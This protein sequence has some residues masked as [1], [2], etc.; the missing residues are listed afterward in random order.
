M[1]FSYP[2]NREP[3]LCFDLYLSSEQ[4]KQKY[5]CDFMSSLHPSPPR[6]YNFDYL[7]LHSPII[8]QGHK[9]EYHYPYNQDKYQDIN[10][11]RC[12]I[13]R[14]LRSFVA[15]EEYIRSGYY[16]LPGMI[17]V[18][19]CK[20]KAMDELTK[21]PIILRKTELKRILVR[22]LEFLPPNDL[23]KLGGIKYQEGLKEFEDL[24][25]FSYGQS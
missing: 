20:E 12:D 21:N 2:F 7:F 15:H 17:E 16:F 1:T 22:E 3:I 8:Y 4:D 9:I 14:C 10:E 11:Y 19:I 6:I 13:M 5:F 24:K 18:C 23:I 25:K